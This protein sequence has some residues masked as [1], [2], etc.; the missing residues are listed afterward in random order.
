MKNDGTGEFTL[1]E[2]NPRMWQ[3]LPCAVR[4]GANFPYQFWLLATGRPELIEPGY[5]VG[6]GTH[7]LFGELK[8]LASILREDSPLVDHPSFPAATWEVLSSIVA[9]PHFDTVR[10]D[11]PLPIV[12]GVREA[13]RKAKREA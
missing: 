9:D 1:T 11:D 3:S 4:E 10:L 7:Y 5:R 13:V 8:Y 12:Y 6:V 2:I